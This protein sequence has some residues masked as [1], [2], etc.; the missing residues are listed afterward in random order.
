VVAAVVM[1]VVVVVEGRKVDE[2]GRKSGGETF[3]NLPAPLSENE[4]IRSCLIE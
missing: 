2:E 4:F 3:Y 1:V